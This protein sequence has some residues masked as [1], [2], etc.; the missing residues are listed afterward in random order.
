MRTCAFCPRFHP[1]SRLNDN[2]QTSKTASSKSMGWMSIL[3]ERKTI[4]IQRAT[5][6]TRMVRLP[7]SFMHTSAYD[8]AHICTCVH[9]NSPTCVDTN[10]VD[11]AAEFTLHYLRSLLQYQDAIACLTNNA[12]LLLTEIPI[13]LHIVYPPSYPPASSVIPTQ[14][15]SPVIPRTLSS[16]KTDPSMI[17]KQQL[18]RALL[19]ALDKDV[20]PSLFKKLRRPASPP[21]S[22]SIKKEIADEAE[23]SRFLKDYVAHTIGRDE[24]V[25]SL[26]QQ[27]IGSGFATGVGYGD[28]QIHPEA[29]IMSLI[30]YSMMSALKNGR[31]AIPV[32]KSES[33]SG[34]STSSNQTSP[35]VVSIPENVLRLFTVSTKFGVGCAY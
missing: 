29:W 6:L 3:G 1:H 23:L 14:V 8:D 35:D 5:R 15:V 21:T 11:P 32:A 2:E 26:Q 28:V 27:T 9:E 25:Q 22:Q 10:D 13:E 24:I 30:Y 34:S 17:R 19:K 31:K 16:S 7:H 4:R 33:S 12:T 20:L 18:K